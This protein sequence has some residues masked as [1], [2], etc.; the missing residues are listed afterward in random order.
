MSRAH[1]P[2]A[3]MEPSNGVTE[4]INLLRLIN[5][6]M[7][8]TLTF[9]PHHAALCPT[10]RLRPVDAVKRSKRDHVGLNH[11]TS[12]AHLVSEAATLASGGAAET[13]K[14]VLHEV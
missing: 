10:G 6:P 11:G 2:A 8:A 12:L 4:K 1:F 7:L 5:G 14:Y 3:R 9:R 13:R